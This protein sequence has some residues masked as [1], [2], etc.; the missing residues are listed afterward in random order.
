[1]SIDHEQAS[2][3][4]EDFLMAM[5]GQL[6]WLESEAA[7]KYISLNL[8]PQTPEQIETLFDLMSQD[9]DEDDVSRLLVV[10]GRYLGEFFRIHHGGQWVLPLDDEKDVN[11]N[12]PVIC[13]H[14]V[15]PEL[16]FA[17]IRV[18]RGYSLRRKPGCIRQAINN[19]INPEILDLGE[20]A[21]RE[22]R[23]RGKRS[24]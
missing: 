5:D 18:I 22:K 21:A 20:E 1:M 17:P 10:F 4:F 3:A 24:A 13:G 14:S 9:L 12:V 2:A 16:E 11:F 7:E 23:G 15:V 19:Q 8:S 6:A